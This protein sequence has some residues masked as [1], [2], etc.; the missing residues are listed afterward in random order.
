MQ[1]KANLPDAQMNVNSIL[2]KDYDK[3]DLFAVRENKANSK[4]NKPNQSQF[5][6]NSKPNKPN[7]SQFKAKQSQYRDG[8]QESEYRRQY[9]EDST[10]KTKDR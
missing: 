6:A 2:S 8:S 10:Q 5:K 3:N 7:Q 9:T 4:P 1:N